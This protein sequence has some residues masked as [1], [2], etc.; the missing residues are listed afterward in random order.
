M[1][2][3]V[4]MCAFPHYARFLVTSGD[5]RDIHLGFVSVDLILFIFIRERKIHSFSLETKSK[6]A[7]NKMSNY[8]QTHANIRTTI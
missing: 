8:T 6:M 2:I 5:Y 7:N 3:R 1:L 4:R